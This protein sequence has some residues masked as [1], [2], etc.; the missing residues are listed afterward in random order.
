MRKRRH[1]T[2]NVALLR[3]AIDCLP[4]ATREAMLDGV[5]SNPRI[6]AGAYVDLDGG[7]C[8]M[9]AAH[10]RGA[11]TAFL[12]FAKSW[13]R[14]THVSHEARPATAREVGILTRQ[15]E[16]SLHNASGLELDVAIAEHR[17]LRSD[18]VR[19]TSRM[20]RFLEGADPSGEISVSRRRLPRLRPS[21]RR[22]AAEAV[23][24]GGGR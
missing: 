1:R 7:V 20:R 11:R 22:N 2:D 4:V 8:P 3:T 5:R 23:G 6:I 12:S 17:A 16:E 24:V 13:D 19:R 21:R 14:F 15:L 10:R 18:R 9:L